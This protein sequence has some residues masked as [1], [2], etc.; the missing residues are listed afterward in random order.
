RSM[1]AGKQGSDGIEEGNTATKDEGALERGHEDGKDRGRHS[2]LCRRS[3]EV[4]PERV[5]RMVRSDRLAARAVRDCRRRRGSGMTGEGQKK[6]PLRA[7]REAE[8]TGQPLP[9][10][11]LQ[12]AAGTGFPPALYALASWYLHGK[13]VRKNYLKAVP[14]LKRAA[15]AGLPAAQYDLATSY[16]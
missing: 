16:A 14:L 5:A 6:Q 7:T 4:Q 2:R 11:L 3:R 1:S 15:D 8:Q 10:G 9:V 13:G 12:Q